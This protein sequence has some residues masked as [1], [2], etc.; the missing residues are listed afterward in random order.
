VLLSCFYA[1]FVYEVLSGAL[2]V[3]F[4]ISLAS[5]CG[6]GCAVGDVG[7]FRAVVA[8]D[9]VLFCGGRYVSL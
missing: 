9:F 5:V 8:P 4:L 2:L 3:V 6:T 7:D 1:C